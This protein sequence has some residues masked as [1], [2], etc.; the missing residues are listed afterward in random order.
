MTN[1]NH[2]DCKHCCPGQQGP[3]G[4]PGPMGLQGIQG[5][6]GKDGLP[7]QNGADGAMGL[8]G[9]PGPRGL[10]GQPGRDG[11]QG[12]QGIAGPMG[13]QGPQGVP[14]DCKNCPC[15]CVNWEPEFAEVYSS[16]PQTLM[17][18]GGPD[19]PGQ[20]ALFENV[21][22]STSNI[23]VTQSAL[24]KIVINKAGWYDIA[25]GICGALNPIP[26]PLP[27]WTLSL[28]KNN[29]LVPGSSFAC[30]TLSPEQKSSE[31]VA[32]VFVHC[33]AGDVLTLANTSQQPIELTAPVLGT[34][35]L[36]NSC[37]MKIILMRA[38]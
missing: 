15:D 38:D 24:G 8:P 30:M 28:F 2:D 37:Y 4:V 18:S 22:F 9:Q 29:I 16:L 17:A 19:L 32:D 7:G 6:A 35:V 3:Q 12:E 26:S 31:V 1:L 25:T 11:Q 10:D 13:E 14:G 34:N 27:V 36:P 23:D 20:L 33:D 5:I 21:I